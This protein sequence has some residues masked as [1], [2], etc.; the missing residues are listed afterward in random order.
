MPG[1]ARPAHTK[2]IITQFSGKVYYIFSGVFDKIPRRNISGGSLAYL[3]G[4]GSVRALYGGM[5]ILAFNS[6]RVPL[7]DGSKEAEGF[8]RTSV[9]SLQSNKAY[10]LRDGHAVQ[11]GASIKGLLINICYLTGYGDA[12][13]R[14]AIS[15]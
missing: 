15:E 1:P 10:A 5:D 8:Q 3:D 9:E 13:Q 12:F 11:S 14:G 4:N 6:D 7:T 2:I